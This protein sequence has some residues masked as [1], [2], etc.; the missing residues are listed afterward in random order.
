M[1]KRRLK[2]RIA[3]LLISILFLTFL[4]EIHIL[5]YNK[6]IKVETKIEETIQTSYVYEEIDQKQQDIYEERA[7][8]NL[9]KVEEKE[10]QQKG[11]IETYENV[12]SNESDE[13]ETIYSTEIQNINIY[14]Y[15]V[16]E[17][18][19]SQEFVNQVVD[20]VSKIQNDSTLNKIT[21]QFYENGWI[22]CITNEDL[23]NKLV[24]ADDGRA[25]S[26]VWGIV[27]RD[28]HII[29]I[30]NDKFVLEKYVLIHEMGHYAD[31]YVYGSS[32]LTEEFEDI[33]NRKK[34]SL[35]GE[36]LMDNESEIFAELFKYIVIGRDDNKGTEPDN[37]VRRIT[38]KY[39]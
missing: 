7:K 26:E 9:N 30:K 34:G 36:C 3:I 38:E 10:E 5:K 24:D 14:E 12:D 19:A 37:Y 17:A 4:V 21:Q 22:I 8:E 15:V 1:K 13:T 16:N 6:E 32:S 11:E 27:K 39:N 29:Y 28:E 23:K 25:I 31:F 18:N 2:N 33:C 35:I 20:Q